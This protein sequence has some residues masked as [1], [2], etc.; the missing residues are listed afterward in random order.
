M[1][2]RIQAKIHD[3]LSDW[4][5]CEFL[6]MLQ[7]GRT[8][9]P[10]WGTW[11]KQSWIRL[12]WQK[13]ETPE[14]LAK[15]GRFTSYSWGGFTRTN[16]LCVHLHAALAASSLE[17]LVRLRLKVRPSWPDEPCTCKGSSLELDLRHL[18]K[19]IQ[20]LHPG[21]RDFILVRTCAAAL[22]ARLTWADWVPD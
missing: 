10:R 9:S 1:R 21:T 4:A 20:G 19:V 22:A 11:R 2:A 18:S 12:V 6:T 13:K 14:A 17:L 8:G 16:F 5:N 7:W 15:K 3:V